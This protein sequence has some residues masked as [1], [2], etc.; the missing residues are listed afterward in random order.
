MLV[1]LVA[2]SLVGAIASWSPGRSVASGAETAGAAA[3]PQVPPRTIVLFGHARSLARKGGRWEL[4]LDPA[5]FLVGVTARRAA[6]EDGVLPPGEPV[7]N[8]YYIRDEGHKLLTYRVAPT[9]RI[10]V[11]TASIRATRVSVSE[12]A[13]ILRG[14]NPAGR[15]L[16]APRNGF[17]VAVTGDTVRSMDQQY[18]P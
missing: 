13:Q 8:D 14:K 10:T 4:R 2:V 5:A 1:A 16:F 3:S 7:P 9:A 18:T 17:W 15:T 12:L 11:L 6:V